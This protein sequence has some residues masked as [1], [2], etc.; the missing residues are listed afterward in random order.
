MM[1][2][3]T[4]LLVG[5]SQSLITLYGLVDLTMLVTLPFSL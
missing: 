1:R 5:T 3:L 4:R 2:V